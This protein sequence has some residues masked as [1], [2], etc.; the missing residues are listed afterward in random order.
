[1]STAQ[2]SKPFDQMGKAV[3][4]YKQLEQATRYR[5]RC[6]RVRVQLHKYY[7]DDG[8]AWPLEWSRDQ[9]NKARRMERNI[10]KLQDRKVTT[11][12]SAMESAFR[13]TF[14]RRHMTD[15]IAART[16]ELMA[17]RILR[18]RKFRNQVRIHFR[19][20]AYGSLYRHVHRTLRFV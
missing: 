10:A 11:Y 13:R 9:I 8:D 4:R 17:R 1:M 6:E 2:A 12:M 14:Y 16:S 5:E 15:V 18:D 7:K 20:E 19:D 3:N